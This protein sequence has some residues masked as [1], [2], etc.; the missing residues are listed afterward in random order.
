MKDNKNY[1]TV[2]LVHIAK[3]LLR[4]LWIIILAG[5][6]LGSLAFVKSAFFT[7]AQYTA[8]IKLYVNN[9]PAYNDNS[10]I[11]ASQIDVAERL[12]MTYREILNTRPTY[13][14]IAARLVEKHGESYKKYT[15]GAL[16]GM[17]SS[18]ASNETE[19][20]YVKVVAGDA[21]DAANI[22]NC[23]AEILPDRISYAIDGASVKVIEDA[24]PNYV[25]ISPDI[26]KDTA[27]GIVVGMFIA[28]LVVVIFALADNK[29]HDE[30]YVI[31]TY[32]SSILAKI[33]SLTENTH[34][35]KYEYYK[36]KS[37]VYKK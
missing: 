34:N 19:V 32:G 21:N 30:E 10:N 4:R 2:D 24:E 8:S 13:E 35:T 6:L 29:I 33:P 36:T 37:N 26:S 11:S 7:P 31:N 18:G 3:T 1:F 12:V 28:A 23:V 15:A 17:I 16:R 22:A 5:I 27:I 25:K 9:E 20:M 14:G